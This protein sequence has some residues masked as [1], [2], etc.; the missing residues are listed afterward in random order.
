MLHTPV[1]C[2]ERGGF[3]IWADGDRQSGVDKWRRV[4]DALALHHGVIDRAALKG[5][6]VDSD[7]VR[8]W[9]AKGML[10]RVAPRVWRLVGSPDHWEQRVAI[11]LLS[12]GPQAAA[13][14]NTA[15]QLHRFDRTPRDVVEFLV[16]PERRGSRM[17]FTVHCSKL[18]RPHDYVTV[19]GF[20]ATSA[21]RTILDLANLGVSPD[22]VS[23]AIDTAVRLQ[24]SAPEAIAERVFDIRRRGR[25]GVRMIDGLLLDAGGHTMLEREFFRLMREGGLP[26]PTPQVVFQDGKRTVARVD[27]L[28]AE[29]NIV[30]EVSGRLGH[31]SPAERA[32][33]AQRRN[34]LQDLGLL[35]FE[36]TWEDVTRR[37]SWVIRQMRER[38]QTAGWSA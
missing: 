8:R 34:E 37:P 14:H 17:Q 32:R 22:R 6:E 1:C 20:Q 35:V 11:G 19:D 3:R 13:S 12:L 38:L 31:S 23:A 7:Q 27:F 4:T 16:P 36:F 15:A 25:S 28:Y 21:T 26:R 5:L 30:V 18:I 2:T 9:V 10:E 29:W 24:L 33:D